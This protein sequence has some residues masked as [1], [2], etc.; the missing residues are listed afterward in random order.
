MTTQTTVANPSATQRQPSRL[1]R[2]VLLANAAFSGV[3]GLALLLGSAPLA[4]FMGVPQPGVLMALGAGLLVFA[5]LL[6]WATRHEI[7][8]TILMEFAIADM[9][10]V[11]ASIVLLLGGW[12]PFTTEGK[13]AVGI[14]AEIVFWFG[15]VQLFAA[16]RMSR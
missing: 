5:G 7:T 6:V 1:G 8:H 3:S 4:T 2:G 15:A 11:L 14:V 9:V 12:V 13:W 16:W 10:W